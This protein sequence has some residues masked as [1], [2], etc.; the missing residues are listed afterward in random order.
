V[1]LIMAEGGLLFAQAGDPVQA[2]TTGAAAVAGQ[3][4]TITWPD[5]TTLELKWI[6]PGTFVRGSPDH[7]SGRKTDEGPQARVT[8]SKGFWLGK[9]LVT[10]A[11]WKK[12]MGL[13]LREQLARR[14]N[15]DTLYELGGKRQALRDLMRWSRDADPATYLANEG[16]ELPM[17]FVSWNDAMEFGERLTEL[18]R[19][20]GRLPVGYQY[21]LPTETQW[22]YACRAGTATATYAGP[23]TP[24][25]LDKIAWYE[26]NSTTGY[27]GRGLG[28]TH[29]GPREVGQKESN[30]WGLRDMC[31][32]IWQWCRDWYGPY[33]AEAATDPT[34]PK[35]GTL[36]VNRGGS[37]GSGANALRS[38]ARAA[39]PQPE[40]SAY[41]G[42]RIALC[43]V[44]PR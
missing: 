8:L 42:F 31:G 22:E 6:P 3:A 30:A 37:F 13:S 41:R 20:A 16:D 1:A 12:V 17:Y 35:S 18:E 29:A 4:L 34:G 21:S 7:E 5:R 11:Q 23:G 26:K 14:I 44:D 19:A 24:E 38:A 10:V 40:A 15:D 36:R 2:E 28:P 32:N 27:A 25:S 39:N 33:S 9:T 43:P